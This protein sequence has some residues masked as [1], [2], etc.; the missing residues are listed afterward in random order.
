MSILDYKQ[1]KLCS[2]IW[3]NDSREMLP[4]VHNFVLNNIMMFF[5]SC[6]I[7]GYE[8]FVVDIVV[9]SSI[10]TYYYTE[11]T[12]IDIK[13]IIDI[14]LFN[15]YNPG[16]ERDICDYLIEK[17]R[18][19]Y[20]TTMFLPGTYH[21]LDFYFYD[22]LDFYPINYN[23][24]DS[25]YS[26]QENTW[27]FEPTELAGDTDT[28][29]DIAY[30]KA[31]PYIE[32]L[33]S[34]IQNARKSIV[35]FIAFKDYIKNLDA[36][37]LQIISDEFINQFQKLN[38]DI[39]DLVI[40]RKLIKDLRTQAFSKNELESELERLMGSFNYSDEN[41]IFKTI[42]RYGFM[43]LLCEVSELF[44]S[45]GVKPSNANKFLGILK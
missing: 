30:S 3:D 14:P 34:D 39:G 23:K 35:D 2:D 9:G 25:L 32:R 31:M 12:D 11:T 7:G 10:A 13:V 17:G 38:N 43:N 41:L 21:P 44:K 6:G 16:I 8:D 27:L 19:N 15:R 1:L 5:N 29:L 28:I 4:E 42:Q 37:D 22:K 18:Q 45:Q 36:E 20:Y 24:Y 40:D 33:M 26:F